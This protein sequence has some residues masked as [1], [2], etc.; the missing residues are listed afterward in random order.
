MNLPPTIQERAYQLTAE[1]ATMA[2]IRR[3][4]MR[5]R[6]ENVDSHLAARSMRLTLKRMCR[7]AVKA[8]KGA[9]AL[10]AVSLATLIT[11]TDAG[12]ASHTERQAAD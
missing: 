11:T 3:Q 1:Y 7:A 6:Y 5:E 9:E 8:R 10:V 2:E 4:L 12:P